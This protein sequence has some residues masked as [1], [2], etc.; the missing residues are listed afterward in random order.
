MLVRMLIGLWLLASFS[1]IIAAGLLSLGVWRQRGNGNDAFYWSLAL[2]G[3]AIESVLSLIAVF[4]T[5][6]EIPIGYILLRLIGRSVK[7]ATLWAMA[8]QGFGLIGKREDSSK[9]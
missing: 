8:L 6:S 9:I 5:P 4:G 2:A 3:I 7:A 1:D